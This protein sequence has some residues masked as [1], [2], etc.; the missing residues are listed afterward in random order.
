MSTAFQSPYTRLSFL[1]QLANETLKS[2]FA[3]KLNHFWTSLY[4]IQV[5]NAFK[6]ISTF[7]QPKVTSVDPSRCQPNPTQ[8]TFPRQ[9]QPGSLSMHQI[10]TYQISTNSQSSFELVLLSDPL[11]IQ[12]G[13]VLR[14]SLE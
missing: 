14:K 4:L 1:E 5:T 12:D 13:I 11:A 8:N 10:T 6:N 3:V 7:T 2:Q 9:H